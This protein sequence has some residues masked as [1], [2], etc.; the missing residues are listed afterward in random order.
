MLYV[1]WNYSHIKAQVRQIPSREVHKVERV[2]YP[3]GGGGGSL[4]VIGCLENLDL[5]NSDLRP[6]N[7]RPSRCLKNATQKTFLNLG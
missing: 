2:L 3:G 5:E 4:F 1:L 7:S 6:E